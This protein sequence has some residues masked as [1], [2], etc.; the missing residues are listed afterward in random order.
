MTVSELVFWQVGFAIA[1]GLVGALLLVCSCLLGGRYYKEEAEKNL[2]Q[3]SLVLQHQ[4]G[5]WKQERERREKEYELRLEEQRHKN[6][7]FQQNSEI[8]EDMDDVMEENRVLREQKDEI[9]HRNEQLMQVSARLRMENAGLAVRIAQA[10]RLGQEAEPGFGLESG[11]DS[12]SEPERPRN[13]SSTLFGSGLPPG[14]TFSLQEAVQNGPDSTG[15]HASFPLDS[16][17]GSPPRTELPSPPPDNGQ[18]PHKSNP[19]CSMVTMGGLLSGPNQRNTW[20][21]HSGSSGPSHEEDDKWKPV[22]PG[23]RR[24]S[25]S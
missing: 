14:S 11:P 16:E 7:A 8:R 1:L 2:E 24:T 21:A 13:F 9:S 12:G 10:E 19:M 5:L 25:V 22:S 20:A 15:S 23:Q 4:A 6:A 18:D 17:P 3:F